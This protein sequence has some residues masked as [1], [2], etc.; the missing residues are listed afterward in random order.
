MSCFKCC[1]LADSSFGVVQHLKRRKL[2][3]C[4]GFFIGM[5]ANGEDGVNAFTV[6]CAVTF[7]VSDEPNRSLL[8]KK[9][10]LAFGGV[11]NSALTMPIFCKE[12]AITTWGQTCSFCARFVICQIWKN[13]CGWFGRC[14]I[15]KQAKMLAFIVRGLWILILQGLNDQVPVH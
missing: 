15:T 5:C 13:R 11:G 9:T 10:S 8:G 7:V 2:G 3:F 6:A 1:W 4:Y 14:L 12:A